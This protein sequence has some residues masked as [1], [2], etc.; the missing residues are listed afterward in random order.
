ML[1]GTQQ[2]LEG[3][4][5]EPLDILLG[6][7]GR[8]VRSLETRLALAER[9][10]GLEAAGQE[11]EGDA[12]ALADRVRRFRRR[13]PRLEHLDAPPPDLPA[14]ERHLFRAFRTAQRVPDDPSYL[15]V[16]ARMK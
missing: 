15:R 7:R 10:A 5:R 4:G 16:L 2:Y 3:G 1:D 8:G 11:L 14:T 6:L 13:W 12:H 9:N